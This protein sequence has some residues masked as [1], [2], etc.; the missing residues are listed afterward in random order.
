MNKV[1]KNIL[2]LEKDDVFQIYPQTINQDNTIGIMIKKQYQICPYC[3]VYDNHMVS[4]Y[5]D[6][7]LKMNQL[8]DYNKL[9]YRQRRYYCIHCKRTFIENNNIVSRYNHYTNNTKKAIKKYFI[10]TKT[11]FTDLAREHNLSRQF[12]MREYDNIKLKDTTKELPEIISIDE[13]C[14]QHKCPKYDFI[15]LDYCNNK[16]IN[17]HRDRRYFSISEYLAQ[18]SNEEREK[19]KI[20]IMDLWKPYTKIT[21]KF[22]PNAIIIAD[23]F[24]YSRYINNSL[25]DLR[26][27]TYKSSTNKEVKKLLQR[28]WKLV[29]KVLSPNSSNDHIELISKIMTNDNIDNNFKEVL[30]LY[31]EFYLSLNNSMDNNEADTF[32]SRI[33]ERLRQF[34]NK[35]V[36]K[37]LSA[38][39]NWK[40]AIINSLK[41]KDTNGKIYSN[42][43]IEGINNLVKTLIKNAYG[44]RRH[45]RLVKKVLL[46]Y[47]YK[48]E[49]SYNSLLC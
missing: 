19:V 1:L 26:V 13:F 45:D 18:F 14:F 17:L 34:K 38:F 20:I 21:A 41:F 10:K 39:K 40:D 25:Q 35:A 4:C 46:A 9:L 16:V 32:L 30:K 7:L 33:I 29:H 37:A 31:N 47:N 24:H 28:N 42:G 8:G 15:M 11:N 23:K 48:N 3:K 2:G 22:F 27:A 12:L 44:F 6:R 49:T 43:R 36:K 5:N